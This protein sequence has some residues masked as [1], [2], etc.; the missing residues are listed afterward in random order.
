MTEEIAMENK[1]AD[2][3]SFALK[4]HGAQTRKDGKPYITHPFAVAVELARNGADEDL[5]CAGLL[6]D[7]IEDGGVTQ[8]ELQRK[9]G[10]EVVRLVLFDTEN[11][12]LSWKER[13]DATLRALEKCDR[14]CA[15]L[16]CADKLSNLRDVAEGL[17]SKGEDVWKSFKYGRKEQEW[18]YKE[19]VEALGKLKDLKMYYDLKQTVDKV[20]EKKRSGDMQVNVEKKNDTAIAFVK[21]SVNSSNAADFGEKLAEIER[22]VENV[23]LDVSDLEY[24]SSAGLRVILGLKKRC[25]GKSFKIVGANSDVMS[26]FDMTGFSEIMDIEPACRK[27][28]VD[29]CELIGKGACG[30]CYR[31]DDE[32]IVKLYYNNAD[33]AFIEHEKALSKKA[34]VMGIPTAI[35]YDIVEANGRKGV[36]YELI[37][38]KTLGE[39]IRAD[40]SRIDEYVE[41]YADICKKVCSVHTNDPEIPSFK[42]INREDIANVTGVS[43]EERRY[44]HRF[45]DL[46]PDSDGCVHGDL[47]INNIMVQDGECCLIDMGELSTGIAMFDFSRILFSMVYANSAPGEYN[48]FYKMQ[49]EEVDEIY[50]KFF[51]AYFG[52]DSVEEAQ[53]TNPQVE[54]LHPLAWFRCCTSMLKGERWGEAN[55]QKALAI[56][57][58]KLIPFVDAHETSTSKEQA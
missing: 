52:C 14:K 2:A 27:I 50:R 57:R 37:K 33:L 29:G 16:I 41:M 34:F 53:K 18:L 49:S 25:K 36:V 23:V 42:D 12:E 17:E 32:A 9:F 13:K 30:E 20:F 39:L 45:L 43:E 47:N 51:K 21:G 26:V 54:W 35:S 1:V 48:G 19:Y 5:I 4:V 7:T 58:E 10:D 56:L 38:S 44:L 22:D 40:R 28:N 31:I 6:H 55:R 46:V 8:E 15:M 11:K 3:F 24:V